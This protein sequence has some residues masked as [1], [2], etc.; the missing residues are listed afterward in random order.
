[1]KELLLFL[2]FLS[3]LVSIE[4]Q[5]R[6]YP[7]GNE[8]VKRI[9]DG[10]VRFLE[11]RAGAN[12]SDEMR[13]LT[14]LFGWGALAL[15]AVFV[16]ARYIS[17]L[18]F[19]EKLSFIAFGAL[20]LWS[21]FTLFR[22]YKKD[23]KRLIL[24]ASIGVMW[25]WLLP[26]LGHP[27][28]EELLTLLKLVFGH[29]GLPTTDTAISITLSVMGLLSVVLMELFAISIPLATFFSLWVSVKVSSIFIRNKPVWLYHIALVYFVGATMFYLVKSE[30]SQT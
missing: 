2:Y 17:P 13:G 26:W 15:S 7:S 18:L 30:L 23:W 12:P 1:M 14:S 28:P 21:F 24:L 11:W 27:L 4:G 25:P 3:L 29:F 8:L 22:D 19:P 20:G 5:I 6:K 16:L 9:S 10:T